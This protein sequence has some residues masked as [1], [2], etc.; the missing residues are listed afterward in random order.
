MIRRSLRIL[1]ECVGAVL[2]ISIIASGVLVWRAAQ[3]PVPLDFLTGPLE[4]RLGGLHPEVD[5]AL[6]S[7]VLTWEGWPETFVLRVRDVRLS[8]PDGRIARVPAVDLR[9]SVAALANGTVAP[10]RITTRGAEI[11]VVRGEDDLRF[12]ALSTKDLGDGA[13]EATEVEPGTAAPSKRDVSPLLP[14]ILNQLMAAPTPDRPLAYLEELRIAD[15]AV[16]FW[17]T[18]LDTAWY[19]P[20]ATVQ[21]RTTAR[22]LS[23][24]ARLDL[25]I[26]DK[27]VRATAS[28]SYIQ[29]GDAIDL[30]LSFD[31]VE[32]ATLADRIPAL[33]KA[34]DLDLPVGGNAV[35]RLGLDGTLHRAT[36]NLSGEPGRIAWPRF[37]PETRP[38]R[39]ASV[40][41][42]FDR[43]KRVLRARDLRVAFGT[44][45]TDGPV[46]TGEATARR[47]SQ[48]GEVAVTAKTR[49]T[50][51]DMSTLGAYWPRG[52]Q[53]NGTARKWITSN[54]REGRVQR[55][56]ANLAATLPGGEVADARL[57]KLS[58]TLRYEGLSVRYLPE[59]RPVRDIDGTAD[60]DKTAFRMQA[61]SGRLRG[62][63]V[64]DGRVVVT[65]LNLSDQFLSVDVG[66]AGPLTDSL[67]PLANPRLDLL[68]DL[69]L[70]PNQAQGRARVQ[71]SFALPLLKDLTMEKVEVEAE[72]NLRNVTIENLVFGKTV[73]N[74]DLDLQV[75]KRG[76]Q[77][78]GPLHIAGVPL[79]MTWQELFHDEGE[80]VREIKG[81]I[82]E[83]S[84]AARKRL[85]FDTA[86]YMN[87]PLSLAL[88][89]RGNGTG[90]GRL[91]AAANL[92]DARLAV[93]A[94]K[95]RKPEGVAGHA[96][97]ELA[98]KDDRP[99]RADR[100][101]IEAGDTSTRRL[102]ADG[103]IQ[104]APVTGDIQRVTMGE[105]TLGRTVLKDITAVRSED[106]WQFRVGGGRI[107]AEPYLDEEGVDSSA[108]DADGAASETTSEASAQAKAATTAIDVETGRL[109]VLRL[110]PER[111][112]TDVRL[113]LH[114]SAS[115]HWPVVRVR[116]TVPKTYLRKQ[117]RK[118][119]KRGP[120]L[121]IDFAARQDG[122]RRLEAVAA[123]AGATLRAFGLLDSIT[124]GRL[125]VSG[126]S[127]T[128]EPGSPIEA[129]VDVRQ[130]KVRDAPTLARLLT[131][132][133]L[134][135]IKDVLEGDGLGFQRLGGEIVFDGNRLETDLLHAYG[136]ALGITAK[137]SVD[138]DENRA[139]L[140]GTLVPAALVN[141]ILGSIPVLGNLITGGE[142][143]GLIAM[144]YKVRGPLDD[145]KVTVNPLAAL[146]PGFLRGLFGAIAEGPDAPRRAIPETGAGP[147]GAGQGR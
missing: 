2:A 36:L 58:G 32:P 134:T 15:A 16:A 30:A 62:V 24:N 147:K 81:Q 122:R 100:F 146:A 145:P 50:G 39:E 44:P 59:L 141:R 66:T 26:G 37:V 104:L 22:G 41:I 61:E 109:D 40:R 72:A 93:D 103:S 130:F 101:T 45:E 89:W 73:E 95:W 48:G 110:G 17:D 143:E 70:S 33:S 6:G 82:P 43:S 57:D 47:P 5:V 144:T 90:S 65:G 88:T 97:V 119:A 91:M 80:Y 69:G 55:A 53:E 83:L 29:G 84:A 25:D 76:M 124:G 12:G 35:G 106:A 7:T 77:V 137:G 102:S 131:V 127:R 46:I 60:F 18:Q 140:D 96:R 132:A 75:D 71:A 142:G 118:D 129:N 136:P 99:V 79:T 28:M 78:A 98:V 52:I 126:L 23:G 67:M 68:S 86:P 92:K 115:G 121:L 19:A 38:V 4:D 139:H 94:L 74:G 125:Q 120:P 34:K 117:E 108:P 3:G 128:P 138:I 21:L 64:Q 113:R 135:G 111:R 11:S 8:N 123:N 10:T 9:L 116:A 31:P 112:L 56:T 54:I 20:D 14:V 49:V 133:L 42:I 27:R 105:L 13:K 85:D 87:G 107:D 51:F 63:R 1:L 114:R